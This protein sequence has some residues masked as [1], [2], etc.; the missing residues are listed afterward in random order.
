MIARGNYPEVRQ[1]LDKESLILQLGETMSALHPDWKKEHQDG[2]FE[3]NLLLSEVYPELI[4]DL[5]KYQ[6][7][8]GG[9]PTD[10]SASSLFDYYLKRREPLPQHCNYG[11]VLNDFLPN[12][13]NPLLK[14]ANFTLNLYQFLKEKKEEGFKSTPTK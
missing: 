7:F 13:T 8:F 9:M 3:L 1:V 4:K 14:A 2:F 10:W 12:I 11:F 6:R 5:D